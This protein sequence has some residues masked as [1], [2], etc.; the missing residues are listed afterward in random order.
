VAAL[1]SRTL[2]RSLQARAIVCLL[3]AATVWG[4]TLGCAGKPKPHGGS[5]AAAAKPHANPGY[6]PERR[7]QTTASQDTWLIQSEPVDIRLLVPIQTAGGSYPLI[8][9]FPGLGEAADAGL[10]WRQSWAQAGFAVLSAQPVKYGAA[11]WS[12]DR[13]RVGDFFDIA[14][15]AFAAPSLAARIEL[16]RGLIDETWRRQVSH[17]PALSRVDMSRIAV[18]GYDLGAQTALML[19]GE[20]VPGLESVP[21]PQS[22]KCVVT[23]SPYADFSGMG[24]QSNFTSIRLPVL[25]VTSGQDTDAYGLVTSAAVRRAPYQYMPAGQKYLLV[26]SSAPHSLLA[27]TP[28]T[29][30]SSPDSAS[31]SEAEPGLLSDR[32]AVSD[33]GQGHKKRRAPA[34]AKGTS[35]ARRAM[36]M[37]QV[38]SVTAAFLDAT[39]K[40]D[41]VGS[42]WLS[43]NAKHWLGESADLQSK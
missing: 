14:K 37:A 19:A 40:N 27:G 4:A 38:Q 13:A 36:E 15:D 20:S 22:V 26:L 24:L 42:E 43:R 10:A 2:K 23:L 34:A 33:A 31:E 3:I 25:S 9:Y 5:A 32:P 8:F 16:A 30:E 7:Y 12:S 1:R 18:A 29:T 39:L 35:S 41:P 17:D 28:I 21:V 11:V 6:A